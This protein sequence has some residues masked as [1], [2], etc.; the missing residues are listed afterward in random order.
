MSAVEI[1]K[2]EKNHSNDILAQLI[3]KRNRVGYNFCSLTDF[4]LPQVIS[5]N[6]DL[7]VLQC[8]DLKI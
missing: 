2:N 3:S 6:Y 8:F 4:L 5:V 1:F 7:Q